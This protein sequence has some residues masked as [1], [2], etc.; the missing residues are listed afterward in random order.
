MFFMLKMRKGFVDDEETKKI[1]KLLLNL[2]SPVNNTP[3]NK[4][5]ELNKKTDEIVYFPTVKNWVSEFPR[6]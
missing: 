6:K 2:S 5:A 3:D 1:A 4:I